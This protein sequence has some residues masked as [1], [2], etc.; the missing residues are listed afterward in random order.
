MTLKGSRRRGAAVD[1]CARWRA[2]YWESHCRKRC[3]EK[4]QTRQRC[5]ATDPA[6]DRRLATSSGLQSGLI[7][8]KSTNAS[9]EYT[10][11]LMPTLPRTWESWPESDKK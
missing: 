3:C 8:N 10:S 11:L 2:C 5:L 7:E 9:A 1:S 6:S 4:V